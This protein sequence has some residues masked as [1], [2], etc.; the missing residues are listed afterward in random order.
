M[1]QGRPVLGAG[2]IETCVGKPGRIQSI[3]LDSGHY[4]PNKVHLMQTLKFLESQG[5]IDMSNLQGEG[6]TPGG[7]VQFNF[8]C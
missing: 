4:K 8:G 6:R 1:N 7:Q 2:K 5:L 3:N